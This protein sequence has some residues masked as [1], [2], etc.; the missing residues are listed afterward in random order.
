M[1][2]TEAVIN[3]PIVEPLDI[4]HKHNPHNVVE[5]KD[6]P[7]T[8]INQPYDE[9][10]FKKLEDTYVQ[11]CTFHKDLPSD[12]ARL[13]LKLYYEQYVYLSIAKM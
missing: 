9:I 1:S 3:E 13:D 10:L 2:I 6:E 4:Q 8:D 5:G 12:R 7:K 11:V